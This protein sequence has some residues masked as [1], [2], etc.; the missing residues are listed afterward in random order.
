MAFS[1]T[2]P[3]STQTVDVNEVIRNCQ[4]ML[5]ILA[6]ED[7]R[8]EFNPT[9]TACHV[10]ME[11]N[12]LEQI[13][14]NLVANSRDAMP[15]G[16]AIRIDSSILDLDAD[17]AKRYIGLKPHPYVSLRVSDN[18]SGIPPE[19]LPR[20]FEPFFSTKE[21]RGTGLGLSSVYGII[22]QHDG[23]IVCD[24]T[25]NEGTTFTIFLP[26]ANREISEAATAHATHNIHRGSERVLLVEDQPA[27]R[28]SMQRILEQNGYRV[29]VASDGHEAL[30]ASN[31]NKDGFDLLIT[32]IGLPEIKGT[33][34]A[35]RLMEQRPRMRVVFMSGYNEEKVPT[36]RGTGFIAKPFR[37]DT[38]I[39]KVREV[40]DMDI[41]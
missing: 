29:V 9:A 15:S 39:R 28:H 16:G 18:G 41:V 5:S 22:R 12:R 31:Q 34:L 13:L 4:R 8:I 3:Q 17:T 1:K 11:S 2:Q 6:G 26:L 30:A 27:L 19:I 33:E 32:D 20:I 35:S 37:R 10:S 38:L 7:V 36:A 21:D 25:P 14:M 24:S 23:Y 40:L